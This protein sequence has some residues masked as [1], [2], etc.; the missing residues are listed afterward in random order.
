MI[1]GRMSVGMIFLFGLLNTAH[2]GW[3]GERKPA[4]A[5]CKPGVIAAS[6]LQFKTHLTGYYPHSSAMEGGFVD[7][8]G[9]P[10]RTLQDYLKGK[11]AYVSVAMDHLDKR[12]PYGTKLRIPS[13]EQEFGKCIEF[14]VVD[15]GQRFFGKKTAK[16]D[17]CNKTLQ[18]TLGEHTNG[19][20]QVFV[21]N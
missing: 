6:K 9:A 17:V 20:A 7:R 19:A 15:T 5:K 2:A 11:T 10:L 1:F 4:P 21:V 18:D 8:E 14:R 3:W 13:I 12:F 16:L